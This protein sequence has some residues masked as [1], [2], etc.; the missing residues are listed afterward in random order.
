V[1]E[2]GRHDHWLHAS[3]PELGGDRVAHVVQAR[4]VMQP[5]FDGQALERAGERIGV[6]GEAITTIAHHGHELPALVEGVTPSR[7]E[8]HASLQL[9]RR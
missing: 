1:T 6:Q 5:G 9:S 8:R 3:A 4:V 7:T 2:D